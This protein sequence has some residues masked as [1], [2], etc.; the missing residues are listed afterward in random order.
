MNNKK[1]DIDYNWIERVGMGKG[2]PG[3]VSTGRYKVRETAEELAEDVEFL[4]R[5]TRMTAIEWVD[6][7]GVVERKIYLPRQRWWIEAFNDTFRY[8]TQDG[9]KRAIMWVSTDY[10]KA[11]SAHPEQHLTQY[12]PTGLTEIRF[13]GVF[14]PAS[15]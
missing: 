9:L 5:F 14:E 3:G 8:L 13:E 4:V 15:S 11:E 2:D 1:L 12:S 7:W 6:K 10:K